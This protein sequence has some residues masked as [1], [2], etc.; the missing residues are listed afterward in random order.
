MRLV[1][2]AFGL[3]LSNSLTSFQYNSV[4]NMIVWNTPQTC[5]FVILILLCSVVSF[6]AWSAIQGL[7]KKAIYS[8]E[9]LLLFCLKVVL[10]QTP[11]SI[12]FCNL[13]LLPPDREHRTLDTIISQISKQR[14]WRKKRGK[15]NEL[16]LICN[17]WVNKVT[18]LLAYFVMLA[19]LLVLFNHKA[20]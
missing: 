11:L 17:M 4:W 7:W 10:R 16:L 18:Y 15:I 2:L 20:K 5:V 13:C 6:V 12:G 1:N 8:G 19:C 3:V 9:L 14:Q